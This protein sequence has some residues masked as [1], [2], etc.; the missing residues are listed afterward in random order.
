MVI[1]EGN[2]RTELQTLPHKKH[3]EGQIHSPSRPGNTYHKKQTFRRYRSPLR[4][5]STALPIPQKASNSPALLVVLGPF[6]LQR[7]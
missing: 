6:L 3:K 2:Q 1:T 4:C 5:L 7:L